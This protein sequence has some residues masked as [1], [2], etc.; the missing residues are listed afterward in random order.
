MVVV[1]I[2][3]GGLSGCDRTEYQRRAAQRCERQEGKSFH[4]KFSDW[5]IKTSL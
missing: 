4:R 3:F 1:M 2:V 5:K